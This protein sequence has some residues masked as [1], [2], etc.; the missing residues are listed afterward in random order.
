M[1]FVRLAAA[2]VCGVVALVAVLPISAQP[3]VVSG[4]T[5]IKAG[6]MLELS[7]P[8]APGESAL[9]DVYP[10]EKVHY[11]VF[12]EPARKDAAGK[13]VAPATSN[14]NGAALAGDVYV[15]VT[16]F[17]VEDG[18]VVAVAKMVPV[19]FGGQKA[20]PPVPPVPDDGKKKD[21][22]KKDDKKTDPT[23]Q[24][25]AVSLVF[26]VVEEGTARTTA[27]AK[28]M[29]DVLF[30]QSLKARGHLYFHYKTT[31][32]ELAQLGYLD[33]MKRA[34]VTPPALLIM[35]PLAGGDSAVIRQ[36]SPL[37]ATVADINAAGKKYSTK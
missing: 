24:P 20:T 1:R 6:K 25:E 36:C 13:I 16:V 4:E 22:K 18:G 27:Q 37:P 29:G 11:R 2:A 15:K 23:P 3:P 30:W 26:A 12:A 5:K 35:S 34:G 14:L 21:D 31:S 10:P 9:W 28:V 19:S 33:E 17:R 7:V 32:P 8:L